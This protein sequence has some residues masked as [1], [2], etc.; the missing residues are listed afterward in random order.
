MLLKRR[1]FVRSA[2]LVSAGLARPLDSLPYADS[3]HLFRSH[4]SPTVC[5]EFHQS[6]WSLLLGARYNYVGSLT[7]VVLW[8]L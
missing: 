5:A 1:D 2:A 7:I 6:A 3:W 4:F 8:D